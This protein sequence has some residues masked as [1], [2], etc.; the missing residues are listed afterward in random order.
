[1]KYE[2]FLQN[3]YTEWYFSIIKNRKL[4]S[5]ETYSEKHHII[6]RC[7]GGTDIIHNMVILTVREHILVHKLLTK[8]TV[9]KI[10]SRLCFAHHMMVR[11]R[12]GTYVNMS[13]RE[14]Q[15][16]RKKLSEAQRILQ[17]GRKHSEET[18]RKISESNRGKVVSQETRDKISKANKGK[19]LG[20][21]RPPEFG[22]KISKA[23][24]GRK[25]NEDWVNKINRNPEKIRKTAEA[26]RGMK[27]SEISRKRMSDSAKKR[28]ANNK[29]K[30]AIHNP[31]TLKVRYV[32]K[33]DPL[34][35]GFIYGG[36]YKR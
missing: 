23:L 7:M 32:N 1:M 6:P 5:P 13:E 25:K 30:V 26:H 3:K 24:T 21:R 9:G 34:P 18:K 20:L 31:E 4:C 2:C 29:G 19:L 8:M 28:P 35:E 17:T 15:S 22:E 27:R 36:V 16:A 33:T 11:G 14:I 10:K 12:Q